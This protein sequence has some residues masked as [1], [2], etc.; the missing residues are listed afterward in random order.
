ME[1]GCGGKS[2]VAGGQ[3]DF[4]NH[5]LRGRQKRWDPS[6]AVPAAAI[7]LVKAWKK[8]GGVQGR[9]KEKRKA[10]EEGKARGRRYSGKV[11]LGCNDALLG[12]STWEAG[13]GG[14]RARKV[15]NEVDSPARSRISKP[16]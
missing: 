4:I 1:K 7:R 13:G 6:R 2:G 11:G 16:I 3:T 15:G 12:A 8:T 14:R 9:A 10:A 5:S